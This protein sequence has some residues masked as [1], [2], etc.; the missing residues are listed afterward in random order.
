MVE[1]LNEVYRREGFHYWCNCI[2]EINMPGY[3][4]TACP[5]PDVLP[6]LAEK[7]YDNFWAEGRGANEYVVTYNGDTGL[8]LG[9]L[10]D[11]S[12]LTEIGILPSDDEAA[13][14]AAFHGAVKCTAEGLEVLVN[15]WA[16][17]V[18][19][20]N[21]TDPDGDEILLFVSS[22]RLSK[23]SKGARRWLDSNIEGFSV[24]MYEAVKSALKRWIK[25]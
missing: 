2:G 17:A 21:D 1:S 4:P 16:D 10:F 14:K 5:D 15:D 22:E 11:Y 20:G 19:Y 25:E 12:W 6:P 9:W 24:R 18:F 13:V 23:K 8:A 7:V 3:P